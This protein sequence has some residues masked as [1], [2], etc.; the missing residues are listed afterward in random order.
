MF[1]NDQSRLKQWIVLRILG[2]HRIQRRCSD[3][4]L[5]IKDKRSEEGTSSNPSPFST[6][7][8]YFG[9]VGEKCTEISNDIVKRRTFDKFESLRLT[10]TRTRTSRQLELVEHVA[11]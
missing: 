5:V 7:Q 3:E 1:P 4:I 8:K 2:I 11:C 6:R 10:L 9:Y